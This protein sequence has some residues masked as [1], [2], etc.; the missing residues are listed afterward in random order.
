MK[1]AKNEM[2]I[3]LPKFKEWIEKEIGEKC[4]ALA[5]LCFVCEA[6][7]LA[8]SIEFFIKRIKEL[9]KCE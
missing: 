4:G 8:G 9:D 5:P 3:D 6:W 7:L 2:G 1:K